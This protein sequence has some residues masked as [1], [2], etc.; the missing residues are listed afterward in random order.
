MAIETQAGREQVCPVSNA[1]VT[2]EPPLYATFAGKE[3]SVGIIT[4]EKR[5]EIEI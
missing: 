5:D 1:I 2:D 4:D 3:K